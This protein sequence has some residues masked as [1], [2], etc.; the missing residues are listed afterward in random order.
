MKG[1]IYMSINSKE[2]FIRTFLPENVTGMNVCQINLDITDLSIADILRNINKTFPQ[3]MK[4][5]NAIKSGNHIVAVLCKS[6]TLEPLSGLLLIVTDDDN[7]I[8]VVSRNYV[9]ISVPES[10]ITNDKDILNV[11]DSI[12]KYIVLSFKDSLPAL[13]EFYARFVYDQGEME[14][15]E[16]VSVYDKYL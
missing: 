12:T 4:I 1:G 10:K 14:E 5:R 3:N 15:D 2:E 11:I 6:V 16:E 8:E 9:V 7:R 13:N